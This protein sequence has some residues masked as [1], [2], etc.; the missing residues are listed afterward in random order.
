MRLRGFIGQ[1][2]NLDAKSIDAQRSVNLF[3]RVNESGT[4]KEQEV[5]ALID[6]PGLSEKV[7]VGDGLPQ[8]GSIKTTTDV[9]YTV[10]GGKL[11][12]INS[13]FT[14]TEIGTLSTSTGHVSMADNGITL[15]IV[16]GSYA[17]YVTLADDT[18]TPNADSD[19]ESFDNVIFQDGY[20]IFSGDS[21]VQISGLFDTTIDALD[22]TT[23][24]GSPD[25]IVG[26]ISLERLLYVANTQTIEAYSNTGNADFPFERMDGSF[27]EIGLAARFS[28]V[29]SRDEI[30]FIGSDKDG[31]GLVFKARGANIQKISTHVI[32][33]K[34]A[35]YGDISE[36]KGYVYQEEGSSF[37]VLNFVGQDTTWV[38]DIKTGMWHER[39]YTNDGAQER[40]RA[41]SHA[42][43]YS[44]H[45]VGDYET[46][47][48]YEMSRQYKTD[49]GEEIVRFR[50][51]PHLSGSG[52]EVEITSLE[53]DIESGVGLDGLGQGT[54][55]QI[56]LQVSKDGGRSFGTE[57]WTSMGK[58]G[59][60][61]ARAKW[62]RL[63]QGRDIVFKVQV[64]D[65]VQ[66]VM[67][68]A[69]AE[70]GVLA[71]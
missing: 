46:G 24:E 45:L 5:I 4:S 2:Y 63:G 52:N 33:Q 56:M 71:S 62:R 23:S 11:F 41:Y 50:V 20:F 44:T 31:S 1:S 55:P 37:Y 54:D 21:K 65:P 16:D 36:A 61:K 12:K 69:N 26:I 10:N 58:I 29:K 67:I 49:N 59:E 64:S 42:Y 34:I 25:T 32:D 38:Y 9:Y 8:R 13:D 60:T 7:N 48:I 14:A 68:G 51:S 40:H 22:F 6:T 66:V 27:L 30:F 47:S 18:F 43:A 28:L 3:P 57:L 15:A 35:S 39:T 17:Y 70:I 19:L 53:I